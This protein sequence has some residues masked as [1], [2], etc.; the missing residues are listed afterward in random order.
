M[1]IHYLGTCSGTEPMPDTHHC[2]L[3]LEVGDAFYW[4]DAGECCV[5]TACGMGLDVMNTR[6]IF[7]SHPH[8]DHIGGLANLFAC[9]G[10]LIRRYGKQLYK[11]NALDIFFPNPEL[12]EAIK[13]VSNSG[14]HLPMSFTMR[15]H[16]TRDGLL[17]ADENIRVTAL[18]NSHLKATG[19]EEQLAY[20]FCIEA[21]GK[22]IVYSGDVGSPMELDPLIGD[23]CDLLIMETGHHRV[24]DVCEYVL[25]RNIAR[26][27]FN[28]HGREIL[29]DRAG[30][31]ALVDSCAA[32]KG[33][34][35][36]ICH[37]KMTEEL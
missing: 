25:Q 33:I 1:K 27:R 30:A 29:N 16:Q 6:A 24:Q 28:H 32:Q 17:Y 2:S 26:L 11:D 9:I 22:R 4:F 14:F 23:S 8:I 15:E 21:E 37:D 5:H 31:Q 19:V 20:S 35:A 12:L 36:C 10:K 7:V 18:H 13:L 34:S 3:I